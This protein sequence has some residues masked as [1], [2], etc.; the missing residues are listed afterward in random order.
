M[1]TLCPGTALAALLDK[2]NNNLAV[3]YCK[4]IL[5]HGGTHD[6]SAAARVGRATGRPLPKAATHSLLVPARCA[7]SGQSRARMH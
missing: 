3:E 7:P 1:E 2:P 4:A 5:E 6:P